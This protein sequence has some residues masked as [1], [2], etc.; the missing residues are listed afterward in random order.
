MLYQIKSGIL[1]SMASSTEASEKSARP[2]PPTPEHSWNNL[3][4][5]K[6]LPNPLTQNLVYALKLEFHIPYKLS[7]PLPPEMKQ[8]V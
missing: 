7:I 8:G 2:L 1:C 6:F 5:W 4:T 3:P